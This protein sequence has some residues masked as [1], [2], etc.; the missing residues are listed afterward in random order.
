[1]GAGAAP[2]DFN[3]RQGHAEYYFGNLDNQR[4]AFSRGEHSISRMTP[5]GQ[6]TLREREYSLQNIWEEAIGGLAYSSLWSNVTIT[7]KHLE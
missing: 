3:L 5:R 1:L 4:V 7:D 2:S 6:I